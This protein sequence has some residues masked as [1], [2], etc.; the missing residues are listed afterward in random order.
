[1][2]RNQLADVLP[3]GHL[4]PARELRL[5]HVDAGLTRVLDRLQ[6]TPAQVVTSLGETLL[7]IGARWCGMA[8]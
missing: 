5:E 8:V 4:T 1:M 7:Q 2:D 6:D 3:T